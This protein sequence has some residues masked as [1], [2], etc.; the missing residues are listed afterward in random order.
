MNDINKN[1]YL[2]NRNNK[3]SSNKFLKQSVQN[4]KD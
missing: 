2:E 4:E 1:D 3:G